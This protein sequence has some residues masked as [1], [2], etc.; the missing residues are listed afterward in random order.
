MQ[1]YY[2]WAQKVISRPSPIGGKAEK[3]LNFVR[4]PLTFSPMSSHVSAKGDKTTPVPLMKKAGK[5]PVGK[6]T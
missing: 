2:W 1:E 4:E 6:K 5:N 3:D